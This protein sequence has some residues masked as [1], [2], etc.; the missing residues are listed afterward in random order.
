MNKGEL[1]DALIASMLKQIE[2]LETLNSRLMGEEEDSDELKE[3][4]AESKKM[5]S[6]NW[7]PSP[8]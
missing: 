8:S 3:A 6:K 7:A 2:L 1:K 5:S 4:L